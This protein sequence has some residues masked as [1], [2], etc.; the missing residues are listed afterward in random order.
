MIR[1]NFG[2]EAEELLL[3]SLPS[4]SSSSSS[5]LPSS[6]SDGSEIRVLS[7]S[8]VIARFRLFV[9]RLVV[10]VFGHRRRY[11]PDAVTDGDPQLQDTE[12][13]MNLL[14]RV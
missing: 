4:S 5:L 7:L 2:Q 1:L 11:I 3:Q 12:E 14:N 8:S 9:N 13:S 10:A 6:I